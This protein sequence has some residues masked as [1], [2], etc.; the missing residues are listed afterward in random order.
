MNGR[1]HGA[2]RALW[3]LTNGPI[4]AGLFVLHRCDN[5]PCCNPDHLFLGTPADNMRD[6]SEKGRAKGA[7][8]GEGHHNAKLTADQV[9]HIRTLI[10]SGLS[11]RKIA[12]MLSVSHGAVG[13]IRKGTC[14]SH[15]I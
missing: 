12:S 10:T 4:P 6:M 3:M 15:L 13:H 1:E 5:P 7:R 11:V 2:H 8:K 14:W 9:R